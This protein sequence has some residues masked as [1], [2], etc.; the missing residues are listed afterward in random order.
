MKIIVLSR[1]LVASVDDADFDFLSQWKWTALVG[2]RTFYAHRRERLECGK[3]ALVLMH[4]LL[5][6]TPA[7]FV[8]DHIDGDG[9]NNIR[10]NLRVA[11][12]RQNMMNRRPQRGGS[13]SIKG[14]W[15]D[16]TAPRKPWR[17]AIRI[18]GRLKYLGRYSD[19]EEAGRAY[20]L[21]A[22]E[23]FGT[24]HRTIEGAPAR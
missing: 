21:A 17:A 7:G 1:G 4:R 5:L 19:P 11:T 24:F 2:C 15:R 6:G 10:S 9:L 23:H 12:Q 20:A 8:T 16:E 22:A 14:V 3:A 13:C 18:D